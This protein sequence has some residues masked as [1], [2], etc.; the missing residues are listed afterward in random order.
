MIF[1]DARK[2]Y[3]LHEY[4]AVEHYLGLIECAKSNNFKVDFLVF[5][6]FKNIAKAFVKKDIKKLINVLKSFVFIFLSLV[7]PTRLK[8]CV[9]VIG[10]APMDWRIILLMRISKHAK[11]IYHSS[12]SDWSGK[13]YPKNFFIFKGYIENNWKFFLEKKVHKFALVTEEVREQLLSFYEIESHN[14]FVVYHAF[15]ENIF[16]KS[17]LVDSKSTKNIVFVGRLVEEKGVMMISDLAASLP[18]CNFTIIGDGVL[19]GDIEKIS[20]GSNNIEYLGFVN[21]RSELAEIY[22]S[23]DFIIQPSLKTLN[24]EELFGMALI[25]AMACGVIPLATDHIGP[26]TI[27]SESILGANLYDQDCFV[28]STV[29]SITKQI[30]NRRLMLENKQCS[31]ELAEKYTQTAIA[32]RWHSLMRDI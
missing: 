16:Y 27:L 15:D 18:N 22:R 31:L 21:S 14:C 19:K 17:R 10:C 9:L 23:S 5:A 30:S 4:G 13:K 29:A 3:V 6:L 8:N 28:R 2:V 12:W 25:E 32:K 20:N 11:V 1:E 7:F 24:W 26:K